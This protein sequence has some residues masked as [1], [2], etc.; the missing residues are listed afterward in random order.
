MLRK[1]PILL[2]LSICSSAAVLSAAGEPAAARP[3]AGKPAPGGPPARPRMPT[4]REY[5]GLDPAEHLDC[6]GVDF[7]AVNDRRWEEMAR[8]AGRPGD[9]LLLEAV[10][11]EATGPGGRAVL[12]VW[13]TNVS[14]RPAR[15]FQ[16]PCEFYEVLMRDGAGHPVRWKGRARQEWGSC[17]LG[18]WMG[19]VPIEPGCGVGATIP[20]A[21]YFE[22]RAPGRYTVLARYEADVKGGCAVSTP[23]PL[24]VEKDGLI[25]NRVERAAPAAA[26]G[27]AIPEWAAASRM[28]GKACDSLV[29]RAL[30]RQ[31]DPRA[32]TLVMSVRNY[33]GPIPEMN[34]SRRDANQPP[35]AVTRLAQ[36][37]KKASNFKILLCDSSGNLLQPTASGRQLLA[38]HTVDCDLQFRQGGAVG[39]VFALRDL[40]DLP[41]GQY[42]AMA[43]LADGSEPTTSLASS[44]VHFNLLPP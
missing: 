4:A 36:A 29:L 13:L 32:P 34:H 40:F 6:D 26:S 10:L 11:T 17:E 22:M 1:M 27:P 3:A 20:L 2:L 25:R 41:A 35:T 18:G 31:E 44:P 8:R 12:G 14:R 39:F 42:D 21:D 38:T 9:G 30:V 37:A 19:Y 7:S 23:L 43:V 5:M 28:A 33:G 24:D 16:P 15:M